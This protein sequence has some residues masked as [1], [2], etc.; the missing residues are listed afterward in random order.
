MSNS[1]EQ[2]ELL[3]CIKADLKC[4][5]CNSILQISYV[6]ISCEHFF[7]ESCVYS[8]SCPKCLVTLS[9]TTF[10]KSILLDNISV[11]FAKFESIL[12]HSSTTLNSSQYLGKCDKAGKF[13]LHDLCDINSFKENNLSFYNT[14][15]NSNDESDC[16]VNLDRNQL[17]ETYPADSLDESTEIRDNLNDSF[18]IKRTQL[19]TEIPNTYEMNDEVFDTYDNGSCSSSENEFSLLQCVEDTY[20]D[21]YNPSNNLHSPIKNGYSQHSDDQLHVDI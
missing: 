20:F 18:S 16:S 1:T 12:S 8:K 2:K 3:S 15:N 19:N 11:T 6:N 21:R 4:A 9:N 5:A 17:A 10:I 7:C 13:N 14:D